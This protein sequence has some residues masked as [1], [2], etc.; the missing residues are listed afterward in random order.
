MNDLNKAIKKYGPGQCPK[1][2]NNL[3]I[4]NSDII[5]S[6]LDESG[7]VV[8]SQEMSQ[9][10]VIGICRICQTKI[11]MKRVGLFFIPDY[12]IRRIL[13]DDEKTLNE[14]ESRIVKGSYSDNPFGK[15]E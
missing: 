15:V 7:Q 12:E 2:G 6:Q 3:T 13:N 14:F 1:C 5:T 8:S 9:A 10:T 11:P 4:I